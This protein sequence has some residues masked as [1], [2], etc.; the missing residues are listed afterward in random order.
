MP[1]SIV[2]GII[3][4]V[5]IVFTVAFTWAKTEEQVQENPTGILSNTINAYSGWKNK[6]CPQVTEQ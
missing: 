4:F 3:A 1:I 5:L 2:T 6:Y